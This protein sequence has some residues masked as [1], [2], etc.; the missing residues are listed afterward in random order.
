M[1]KPL[2]KHDLVPSSLNLKQ[3]QQQFSQ[4]LLYQESDIALQLKEKQGF[5]SQQLLQI[6]RNNFVMSV[7]ESLKSTFKYTEQLVG[8][9][10]FDSVAR[11]FILQQPPTINNIIVYGEQFPLYLSNLTQLANMPYIAEMAKFEWLYEQCQKTVQQPIE[12]DLQSLQQINPDDFEYLQF[13]IPSHC[14]IFESSQNINLLYQMLINNNVEATNL[15]Q[16]C[17][18]LLEKEPNFTIKVTELTEQQ[19][20][21]I[22]QLQQKVLLGS[23]QPS[24]LQEQLSYLITANLISDFSIVKVKENQ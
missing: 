12:F 21:L 24:T 16:Q 22:Q 4:S 17:Y 23:L 1:I 15:D 7:T 2:N 13:S 11:Q 3:L 19:W 18:L 6:H 10:F 14:L 9:D 20:Q 5:T 8:T